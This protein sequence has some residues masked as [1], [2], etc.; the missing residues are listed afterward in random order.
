M[1]NYFILTFQGF[2]Y[3]KEKYK[4][5]NFSKTKII[6]V[7]N[8]NQKIKNFESYT[9][10]KNLGCAGG[11]NLICYIGF[12]YLNLDK[13]IIGQDDLFVEENELEQLLEVCNENSI[14][15]LINPHFEFSTFAI[16]KDTF[17]KIGRFDEN[18][19][20]AY[21]ED[22]DYK[23]RCY[24]NNVEIKSLKKSIDKNMGL[25]RIKN[26]RIFDTIVVNRAYIKKKWGKSTNKDKLSAQD[27]Q[28]PYEYKFPFNNKDYETNFLPITDRM[29][30]IQ[31][32]TDNKFLSE[33]EITKFLINTQ[34]IKK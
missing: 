24:L 33:N 2:E 29:K 34:E 11:W 26:T 32:I 3:F 14:A 18:C 20:D 27:E 17:K 22:T 25:S 31:N 5:E 23:Q 13:I 28:P 30:R 15:G 8:G 1:I 6:I 16:H 10:S 19:I 21:C 4:Y 9:S 7:D 12:D